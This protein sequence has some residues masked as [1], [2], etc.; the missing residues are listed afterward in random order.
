M[1]VE[2]IQRSFQKQARPLYRRLNDGIFE[3]DP[4]EIVGK[5]EM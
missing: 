3:D 4:F 2:E 1:T 5:F